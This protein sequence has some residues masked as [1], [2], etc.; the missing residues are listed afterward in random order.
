[1]GDIR[2]FL[3]R[4]FVPLLWI[5]VGKRLPDRHCRVIG[6][7]PLGSMPKVVWMDD[8]Y[9]WLTGD[10]EYAGKITA[11]MPMPTPP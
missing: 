8:D 4:T 9:D 11:W 5:P 6:W 1:M 10:G 3:A 7:N 2:Y